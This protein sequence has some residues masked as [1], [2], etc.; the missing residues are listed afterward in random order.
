MEQRV[1][2]VAARGRNGY[3][4]DTRADGGSVQVDSILLAAL[5]CI[6]LPFVAGADYMPFL[7]C[8]VSI[9]TAVDRCLVME[10]TFSDTSNA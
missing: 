1:V 8:A 10:S 7:V 4:I 3:G 2:K 5:H 9:G 6:D